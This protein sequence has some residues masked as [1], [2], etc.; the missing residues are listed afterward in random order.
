MVGG[1]L[2]VA[3]LWSSLGRV[4]PTL[5][6]FPLTL[7]VVLLAWTPFRATSWQGTTAMLAGQFG[8]HGFGLGDE[9]A[10]ALRPVQ[11]TWLGIAIVQ[12][13]LI[14]SAFNVRR[15]RRTALAPAPA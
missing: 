3:R 7:L 15:V 13:L 2:A 10:L 12:G 6:S 9:M 14:A 5:I 1:A 8:L 4:L 11:L